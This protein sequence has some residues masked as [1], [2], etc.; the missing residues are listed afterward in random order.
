MQSMLETPN[1]CYSSRYDDVLYFWQML[2]IKR[3]SPEVYLMLLDFWAISG[4]D[5]N[6]LIHEDVNVSQ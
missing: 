1:H 3:V 5:N 4:I 6:D 2:E